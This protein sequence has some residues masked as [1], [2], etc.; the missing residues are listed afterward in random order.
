MFY[1]DAQK[2]FDPKEPNYLFLQVKQ[3]NEQDRTIDAV[4]STSNED[5]DGDIILPSAIKANLKYFRDN[6]VILACHQHRLSTG[7]SPVIG[8]G[9]PAT[10]KITDSEVGLRIRFANT[11]L[12]EEYWILYRDRDM[13]AFSIGFMPIKWEE[14]TDNR[15]RYGW[16]TR[17]YTEI[18]LLEI[19]AV[20][21]P[22]NRQAL[23]RAMAMF[24]NHAE[25]GDIKAAVNDALAA[26]I[27]EL[28]AALT[29]DYE[30]FKLWMREELD[31][32][33]SLQI[34]DPDGLAE[35]YSGGGHPDK[36][37]DGGE[38]DVA[39]PILKQLEEIQRLQG[40]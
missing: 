29:A 21:V 7:S 4:A 19:S 39:A 6:P 13:R 3:I 28:K 34:T 9:L 16:P 1:V 24:D 2:D 30:Q 22:S 11:N 14:D 12:G 27:N 20:P 40:V 32:L 31:E 10:I 8:S 26:K 23:A 35:A 5:R 38:A 33:K 18:E 25:A 17:T 15:N 37:G 36:S